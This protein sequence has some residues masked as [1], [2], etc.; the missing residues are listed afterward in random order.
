MP[1][2]L[3]R[4]EKRMWRDCR[5]SGKYRKVVWGGRKT[6]KNCKNSLACYDAAMLQVVFSDHARTQ[7]ADRGITE[8]LVFRAFEKAE[9]CFLQSDG[10]TRF[11]KKFVH[12][13]KSLAI[14]VIAAENGPNKKVI[15][16]FITSKIDKYLTQ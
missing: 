14:V 4:G 7:M 1:S 11:V 13:G 6:K 2:G 3:S 8:K 9:V 5:K 15:T 16:A 12:K 10:R